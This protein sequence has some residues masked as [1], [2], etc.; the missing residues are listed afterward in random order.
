M[1]ILYTTGG[2][3][4]AEESRDYVRRHGDLKEGD[5]F[6]SSAGKLRCKRV[7]H[8]VGPIWHDGSH[9]ESAVLKTVVNKILQEA[10]TQAMTSV[11]LPAISTGIFRYPLQQATTTI[12]NTAVDFIKTN[13][14]N[15][16]K[17]IHL[18]DVSPKTT[19]AF[20]DSLVTKVG[21]AAVKK[22]S[23]VSETRGNINTL[24]AT[25]V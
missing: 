8:A 23:H 11:A 12:V 4:I 25:R 16:L 17:Y 9:G 7:I 24:R 21:A 13:N 2:S 14:V 19:S 5:I 20:K 10:S 15:N 1:I 6:V 18:V 3:I 22:E